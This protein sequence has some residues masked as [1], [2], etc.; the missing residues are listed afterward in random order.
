MTATPQQ[1]RKEIFARIQTC[2]DAGA[3]A[4]VG[5][6]PEMRYQGVEE[7][8]LPGAANFW[9]RASTQLATTRQRGHQ[10]L[11]DG[12]TIP[13]Y[14]TDGALFVQIYAPMKAPSSYAKGELLAALAQR[15]FM[16]ATTASGVWFRNPRINEL[17][18][19]GTWYRWNVIAD[20]QFS[21]VKGT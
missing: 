10:Q 18:N 2:W 15:M 14:E 9:A 17:P 1:A 3:A 20:Y 4:I 6:V 16:G 12:G 19:D 13:F 5:T 21:Q 11:D 7:K 8:G